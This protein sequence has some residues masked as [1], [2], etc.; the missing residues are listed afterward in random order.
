MLKVLWWGR[1][2]GVGRFVCHPDGWVLTSQCPE[3]GRVPCHHRAG[4]RD[5]HLCAHCHAL[6]WLGFVWSISRLWI[7]LEIQHHGHGRQERV[8]EKMEQEQPVVETKEFILG[9][10]EYSETFLQEERQKHG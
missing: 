9:P 5:E 10:V 7:G 8:P 6:P 1:L 2:K 4:V 3:A